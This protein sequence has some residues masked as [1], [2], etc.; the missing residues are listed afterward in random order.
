MSDSTPRPSAEER[1]A[2]REGAEVR[3]AQLPASPLAEQLA[4]MPLAMQQVL[5]ELQV[6]Q[7]ELEMQNDE[8]RRAQAELGTAQANYFDFYDL[9]PVGYCTVM[10]RG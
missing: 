9:G 4:Q 6:H 1:R 7:I 8:L 10:P 2:L 3:F 5:H